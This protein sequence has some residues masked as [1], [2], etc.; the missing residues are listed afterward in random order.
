MPADTVKYIL[1][2]DDQPATVRVLSKR[3]LDELGALVRLVRSV[4]QAM[5]MIEESLPDFVVLDLFLP[6]DWDKLQATYKGKIELGPFN[7]GE[8]LGAY[9]ADRHIPFLYYTSHIGFY[10][11]N[12]KQLVIAKAKPIVEVVDKIRLTLRGV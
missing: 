3:L 10:Q 6:Q 9:L 7:Q 8:L 5:L 2:V 1:L 12:Q 4:N 11:G